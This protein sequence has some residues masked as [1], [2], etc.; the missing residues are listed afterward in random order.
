MVSRLGVIFFNDAL[1]VGQKGVD[2][3]LPQPWWHTPLIQKL[4]EQ[5]QEDLYEFRASLVFTVSPSQGYTVKFCLR[6]K[7]ERQVIPGKF[8]ITECKPS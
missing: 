2:L 6:L 7:R 1:I 5:R 8:N 3:D 4:R